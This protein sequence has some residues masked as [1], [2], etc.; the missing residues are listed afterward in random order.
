MESGSK[1][2]GRWTRLREDRMPPRAVE[3][4][5]KKKGLVTGYRSSR[6]L[7]WSLVLVSQPKDSE[8]TQKLHRTLNEAR[9]P[10]RIINGEPERK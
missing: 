2:L 9:V 6:Y 7:C 4:K 10:K 1:T 5:K 3:H 8:D